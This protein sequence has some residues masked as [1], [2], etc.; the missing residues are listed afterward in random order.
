MGYRLSFAHDFGTLELGE[1]IAV[2]G[3]CLTV[4]TQ[5]TGRFEADAS[6]E[7]V[8]RSTLGSLTMGC[9]VHLERALRVGD[10]MGGHIVAGHVDAVTQVLETRPC[11]EGIELSFA[12]SAELLPFMAEKGS[13]A[14]DGVS[15]TVNRVAQG[16]F[17]VMLVPHTQQTTHLGSLRRGNDVN[18]EVDVLARYV[19][20]LVRVGATTDAKPEPSAVVPDRDASLRRALARAGLL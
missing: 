2:N 4:A 7:S 14:I 3:V 18:V 12:L 6:E 8:S 9:A 20:H 17:T 19:V 1:S 16:A 13:V 15:L 5:Q 10:R 11:G